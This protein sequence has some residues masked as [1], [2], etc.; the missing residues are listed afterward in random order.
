MPKAQ[1]AEVKAQAVASFNALSEDEKKKYRM[2]ASALAKIKHNE[3]AD[4]TEVA[5]AEVT[6][7]EQQTEQEIKSKLVP[8]ILSSCPFSEDDFS[9]M[10]Q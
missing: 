6:A 5:Q 4:D 7:L 9:K 10:A 8:C 3:L 2:R 1:R